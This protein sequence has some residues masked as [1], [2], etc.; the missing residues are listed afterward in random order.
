VLGVEIEVG[1]TRKVNMIIDDDL[2]SV[3][4]MFCKSQRI[5]P[6]ACEAIANKIAKAIQMY[7]IGMSEIY[8]KVILEDTDQNPLIKMAD[9]LILRMNKGN[10]KSVYCSGRNTKG[11]SSNRTNA[12]ESGKRGV[13]SSKSRNL[14]KCGIY[15]RSMLRLSER[16]HKQA[17]L[18]QEAEEK[19]MEG[20]TFMP[21]L[22]QKSREITRNLSKQ[23]N[24]TRNY[25]IIP[26]KEVYT[27]KPTIN[28]SYITR[29]IPHD[30]FNELYEDS[31]R[32]NRLRECLHSLSG[33]YSFNPD[34][35]ITQKVALGDINKLSKKKCKHK[36][37]D[38]YDKQFLFTPST[39]RAPYN[40][41]KKKS[42]SIGDY[43]YNHGLKLKKE[44]EQ[45]RS[46]E[47][48]RRTSP[49]IREKSKI[50]INNRRKEA[51]TKVFSL[52][53]SNNDKK[54]TPAD[55]ASNSKFH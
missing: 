30:R 21:E 12:R 16:K 37:V 25:S 47:E 55:I 46:K 32:R 8:E 49:L 3:A 34:I 33:N 20:V 5:D 36:S 23:F 38:F 11:H 26:K 28:S 52:L 54:I 14:L 19:E 10:E 22:N 7:S 6:N 41:S 29:R 15:E 51:F 44:Q 4:R 53:D 48:L 45:K 39:G 18:R 43:L 40:R 42:E 24:E 50:I 17:K 9:Q 35:N 1:G 31:K 13:L 27:F 2:Y